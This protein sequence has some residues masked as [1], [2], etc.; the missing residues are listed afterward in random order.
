MIGQ[1]RAQAIDDLGKR[2]VARLLR[3]VHETV[4]AC[5]EAYDDHIMP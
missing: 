2:G 3:F 1:R 4:S 5:V